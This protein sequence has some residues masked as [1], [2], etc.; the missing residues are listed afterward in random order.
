VSGIVT[1]KTFLEQEIIDQLPGFF[2][3]MSLESKYRLVNN[4]GSKWLGFK[5]ADQMIDLS[6]C[7]VRCRVSEKAELSIG[8]D[9]IVKKRGSLKFIGYYSYFGDDWKIIVGEKVLLKNAQ[10][11]AA[12]LITRFNDFTSFNVVDISRFLL[13]SIS[14]YQKINEKQFCY[15][16]EDICS[17]TPLSERQTECLFFL[18]RGK[19]AKEIAKILNISP[20]T[21]ECHL[22]EIKYK[23]NCATKSELIEKA[24][25]SGYINIFPKSLMGR[26]K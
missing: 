17:D 8:L 14:R 23:L 3:L 19:T 20:R 13:D 5:S 9:N 26:L 22:E 11:E 1:K 24:I 21:T 2:A 7:D 16:L 10:G 15:I 6:Y 18:L 4:N 25:A 12:G